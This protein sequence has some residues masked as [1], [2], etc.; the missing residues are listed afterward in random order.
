MHLATSHFRSG[1][2]GYL[3][4][5]R[6]HISHRNRCFVMRLRFVAGQQ[7]RKYFLESLTDLRVALP[8]D[9]G[10]LQV[11]EFG[12]TIIAGPRITI[13]QYLLLLQERSNPVGELDFAAGA[14][15]AVLQVMEDA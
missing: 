5:R 15:L 1:A 2:N 11:T 8:E 6:L 3:H 4:R 13:G 10:R 9:H 7:A 14:G 12:A